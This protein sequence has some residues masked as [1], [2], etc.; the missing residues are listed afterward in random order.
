MNPK[1]T[2]SARYKCL[3]YLKKH[4]VDLYLC[5][6][7]MEECDPGHYYGP[8]SRSEYLIH[9]VLSGKAYSRRTE[10]R[11]TSGKTMHL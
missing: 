1:F 10:K 2:N 7:G 5:Y 11:I 6:C 8:T 3:E 9:Y 4:S